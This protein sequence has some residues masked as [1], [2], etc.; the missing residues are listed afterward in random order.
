M[1]VLVRN[2]K[3]VE[4][5]LC[6]PY[7]TQILITVVVSGGRH[8]GDVFSSLY[9]HIFKNFIMTIYYMYNKN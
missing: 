8:M 2:P 6:L 4:E 9:S 5:K 7:K 3:R 1:A